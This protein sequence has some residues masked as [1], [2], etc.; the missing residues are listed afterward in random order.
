MASN[1]DATKPVAGTPTT[2]SVRD[3]FSAAKSEI[4]ALQS[5]KLSTAHV[6]TDGSESALHHTLGTGANQAASGA[7][8]RIVAA[9]YL[10]SFYLGAM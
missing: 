5:G 6:D 7:D 3:N 9:E 2:Q 4:E 10:A 1:I 8:A